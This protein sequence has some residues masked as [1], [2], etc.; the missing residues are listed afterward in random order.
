MNIQTLLGDAYKDGMT[1]DEIN[2]AIAEKNLVDA[3]TLP[4]SVAKDVFD[5]TA[6][7]LAKVKKELAEATGASL[8]A[9]Q[10]AQI[11]IEEAAQA[12]KEYLTRSARLKAQE[13]LTSASLTPDDYETI[14]DRLVSEDEE[15]T[16]A[17]ASAFVKIITA[18][19]EAANK[20]LKAEMLKQTPNT[21]NSVPDTTPAEAPADYA[22]YKAW[23]EKQM[24]E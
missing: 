13:I 15:A 8:S 5:K 24:K 18:Q 20:A 21:P 16:K 23:R 1:I 4:K 12:K 7:E 17:N 2:A 14:I 9:E 19:K 6:S 22:A 3:S 11:A 10:K